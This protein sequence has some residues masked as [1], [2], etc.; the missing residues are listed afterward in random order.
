MNDNIRDILLEVANISS[1]IQKNSDPPVYFP[2]EMTTFSPEQITTDDVNALIGCL[3]YHNIATEVHIRHPIYCFNLAQQIEDNSSL[4]VAKDGTIYVSDPC[5]SIE[6]KP[7]EKPKRICDQSDILDLATSE[8]SQLLFLTKRD[9]SVRIRSQSADVM[10]FYSLLNSK[11][12][13][14]AL[15][16]CENGNVLVLYVKDV[17]SSTFKSEFSVKLRIDIISK[18]GI[19]KKIMKCD[20]PAKWNTSSVNRFRMTENT[21]GHICILCVEQDEFIDLSKAGKVNWKYTI[22][23]ANDIETTSVGNIIV[24]GRYFKALRVLS[25]DGTLLTTIHLNFRRPET[26]SLCFKNCRELVLISRKEIFI[27]ELSFPI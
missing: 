27:L 15:C 6:L 14:L 10:A 18:T 16:V 11:N 7:H 17:S 19:L 5:V 23:L 9:N 2:R 24:S 21:N 22:C 4:A 12:V 20:F 25:C 8:Q 26:Y 3:E 1:R 13:A